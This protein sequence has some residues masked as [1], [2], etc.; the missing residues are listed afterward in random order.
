MRIL[1]VKYNNR[2]YCHK[3]KGGLPRH[4]FASLRLHFLPTEHISNTSLHG[5]ARNI[6]ISGLIVPKQVE[7]KKWAFKLL[8][9]ILEHRV[10]LAL[11]RIIHVRIIQQ[12]LYT[13]KHLLNRN[14]R[15][16]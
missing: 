2:L 13:K 5:Y 6:L 3:V 11:G 16:P 12:I 4:V 8:G 14:R 1:R 9:N 7:K 15:F 10:C